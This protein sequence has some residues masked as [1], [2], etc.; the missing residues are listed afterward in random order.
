MFRNRASWFGTVRKA[1]AVNEMMLRRGDAQ[2]QDFT[3]RRVTGLGNWVETDHW[4]RDAPEGCGRR[5]ASCDIVFAGN[6]LKALT[7]APVSDT[8]D[9]CSGIGK[10][11]L[12]G[13]G[14]ACRKRLGPGSVS[15]CL[16]GIVADYR[17]LRPGLRF[18][19]VDVGFR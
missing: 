12:E 13:R 3:R 8:G 18:G 19:W 17:G 15:C 16:L 10:G 7:S 5:K 14:R 11:R 9:S 6:A 1:F 4:T 2:R